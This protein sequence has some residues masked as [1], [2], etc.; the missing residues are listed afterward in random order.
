MQHLYF[1]IKS[2]CHGKSFFLRDLHS[3]RLDGIIDGMYTMLI[4][5]DEDL[6]R[7][8]VRKM[9]SRLF[10]SIEVVGEADNAASALELSLE[11]Q[12]DIIIMDINIPGMNGLEIARQ[13]Q[14]QNSGTNI[15]VVSAHDNFSFAQEAIRLRLEGYLL[16]P[17]REHD[18]AEEIGRILEKIDRSR[19]EGKISR[20]VTHHVSTYP[21]NAE[22]QFLALLGGRYNEKIGLDEINGIVLQ[23]LGSGDDI[24]SVRQNIFEFIVVIRRELK[25]LRAGKVPAIEGDILQELG[26]CSDLKQ[27]G[28]WLSSALRQIAETVIGRDDESL[29]YKVEEYL[30]S[31]SLHEVSLEH[32]SEHLGITPQYLSRIFKK[33]Y[34]KNFLEFATEKRIER[35]KEL[36]VAGNCTVAE[37]GR[38]VG[39]VDAHYFSRIFRQ[40]TGFTPKAY[41][42]SGKEA[43]S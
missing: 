8:A 24:T 23:F 16:K 25:K 22:K 43:G 35:A 27:T 37:A 13:I 5:D 7:Y 20:Q 34:G 41:V 9:T 2:S 42:R 29:V 40:L 17:V 6:A 18:F 10:N 32:I 39:Y 4:V 14:K 30:S 19:P 3:S 12:P 26:E 33:H 1:R 21:H 11:L 38:M 28:S 31:H 36:L 15:L